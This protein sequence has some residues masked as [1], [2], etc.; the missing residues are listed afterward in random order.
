VKIEHLTRLL[1]A[2]YG[3]GFKAGVEAAAK[4]ADEWYGRASRTADGVAAQIRALSPA[5]EPKEEP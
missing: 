3:A 4:V 1:D 5:A 2:E